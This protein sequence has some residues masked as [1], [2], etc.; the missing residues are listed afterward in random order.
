M[1][2]TQNKDTFISNSK[3]AYLLYSDYTMATDST[4]KEILLEMLAIYI[5]ALDDPKA[6]LMYSKI[7]DSSEMDK[8]VYTEIL[9][10]VL[11]QIN[12]EV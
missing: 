11:I 3:K 12:E 9:G 4:E 6:T 10:D 8:G 1:K 2:N 7:C 5:Y